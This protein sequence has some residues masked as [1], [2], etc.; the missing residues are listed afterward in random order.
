MKER[1][2]EIV[3]QVERIKQFA[4]V[5]A[6]WDTRLIKIVE[7]INQDQSNQ[8]QREG[9]VLVCTFDPEPRGVNQGYISVINLA[10]RDDHEKASEQLGI[11]SPI[12]LG[13]VMGELIYLPD[14][15]VRKDI[16]EHAVLWSK[17]E[18]L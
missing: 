3:S 9:K 7:M 1:G 16:G 13:F 11:Q 12:D 2:R 15:S 5:L 8:D 4:R 14:G 17:H 10:L 6:Q 18:G